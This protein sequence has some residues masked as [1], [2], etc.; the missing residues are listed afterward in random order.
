MQTGIKFFLAL[1]VLAAPLFAGTLALEVGN[2]AAN[3]EAQSK[4]AA[5]LA[6]T[7]ACQSPEKTEITA[8]AEGIVN[9]I[10]RSVPLKVIRLSTPGT[11]VVTHEWPSTGTWAVRIVARNPVYKNYATGLLI[12]FEGDS[13][14]WAAVKH[15][16]HEPTGQELASVLH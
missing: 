9:G 2:P 14:D 12:P 6:R 13:I 16:F 5:V 7:T 11:F 8:T 4:H 15:Y 10:H 3:A 1:S